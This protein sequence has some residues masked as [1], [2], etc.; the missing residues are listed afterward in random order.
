MLT[1]ITGTDRSVENRSKALPGWRSLIAAVLSL[2]R[3][4]QWV[5]NLLVP[6]P[7]LLGHQWKNHEVVQNALIATACFCAAASAV[8]VINDLLDL[9]AD[10][11]HT[12]KRLRPIAAGTISKPTA[13]AIGLLFFA[14]A[15]FLATHLPLDFALTLL[16][17]FAV[18]TLY[19]F[20]LKTKVVLDICVLAGLYAIRLFAGGAATHIRISEWTLAFAMFCFLGL[21]AV[22]RYTELQTL[23]ENPAQQLRRGYQRTDQTT[24]QALGIT[25]MMLSVLVLAL[26]LHSPEVMVLYRRPEWLWLICPVL[27]Y[28]FGRVWIVAGRGMMHSDPIV[29]AL[30]DRASLL[31]A[32]LIVAIGLAC[33]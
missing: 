18:S 14:L 11:G 33:R 20:Y 32:A 9:E 10:R 25:S 15:A 26:Y 4:H 28:W 12:R 24:V 29:F 5:K 16:A 8:Y 13:V 17:Y 22:K 30:R 27:L 23:T 3:P 2:L 1:P 21:A 31:S 7:V 6:L 19:S